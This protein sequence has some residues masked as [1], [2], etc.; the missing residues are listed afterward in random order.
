MRREPHEDETCGDCDYPIEVRD[1]RRGEFVG[2]TQ[3]PDCTWTRPIDDETP[4][5][6]PAGVSGDGLCMPAASWDYLYC[7]AILGMDG[8]TA[9]AKFGRSNHPFRRL[10]GHRERFPGLRLRLDLVMRGTRT[11]VGRWEGL[12]KAHVLANKWNLNQSG[13]WVGPRR[14]LLDMLDACC[15]APAQWAPSPR[16]PSLHVEMES[17]EWVR[18]KQCERRD[19]KLDLFKR[20]DVS[21]LTL[22]DLRVMV[23]FAERGKASA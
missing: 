1:G 4:R 7:V 16:P 23:A 11:D 18:A 8:L 10:L 21:T 5:E 12:L 19:Q 17:S 22:A 3:F 20:G 15:G 6:A 2:C 14:E 9:G 13:E